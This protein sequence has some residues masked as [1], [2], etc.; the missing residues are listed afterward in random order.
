VPNP[1]ADV[2]NSLKWPPEN[3]VDVMDTIFCE[4]LAFFSKNNVTIKL[5]SKN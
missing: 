2:F 5:F 3:G 1:A 4:K